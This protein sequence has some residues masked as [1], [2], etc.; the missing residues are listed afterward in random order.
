MASPHHPPQPPSLDPD[1]VLLQTE[2]SMEKAVEY[3]K[4]E[5]KGIRTG[6]ASPAMVEFVKVDYYGASTDLKSLALI[7]VPEPTQL[8]IKPFDAGSV[9]EIK[10][11]IEASGLGLNPMSEGKQIRINVPPLSGERRQQ[12]VSKV[13]KHGEETKVV[14]RN[15]RRDAN[16]HADQIKAGG[17]H[18]EDEIETLKTE[19]QELLKKFE[20]D[21]D[22]RVEEKSREITEV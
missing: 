15:H 4:H 7:S 14:L 21:V 20:A 13:K 19:I 2:E 18:S 1:T 9:Q 17:H 12:L 8:L 3:L 5:L 16:K 6:R 22:K 11:A 10:K